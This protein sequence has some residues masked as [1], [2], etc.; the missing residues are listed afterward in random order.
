MDPSVE[1]RITKGE[2]TVFLLLV[3]ISVGFLQSCDDLTPDPQQDELRYIDYAVNLHQHGIFGLSRP[4]GVTQPGYANAPLYPAFLAGL[5][6]LSPRFAATLSCIHKDDSTREYCDTDYQVLIIAQSTLIVVALTC[7]WCL[8]RLLFA[9]RSIA[10][11]AVALA[12]ASTKPLFFTS[13]F[14]TEILI[15]LFFAMLLLSLALAMTRSHCGWWFGVGAVLGLLSLT[16]PEYLYLALATLTAVAFACLRGKSQAKHAAVLACALA[17]T[18]GP[19]LARNYA[20]FGR[21]AITGAYSDVILAYRLAYNN[22]SLAEWG[23]AFIYWLP[24]HGEALGKQLLPAHTYAKL[25]TDPKSYLY[26]EGSELFR[27]HLRAVDGDR[28]RLTAQLIKNEI[29]AHP[30]KHAFAALPLT[31]RGI[32]AGKYLAV[33]GVP[34]LIALLVIKIRRREWLVPA[35]TLPAAI[36]V[37][38]YAAVSVSIPRYNVYLIYYYGLATAWAMIAIA[39]RLKRRLRA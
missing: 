34:C 35:L 2:A 3:C 7:L 10:W 14:L 18:V 25:G 21:F 27:Q 9:N 29:I 30:F 28:K 1:R 16:R 15:L 22:M 37:A 13:H 39:D 24:G 5:M 31:W 12:L 32:L 33:T 4:G 6:A 26:V 8:A 38:L 20:H 11:L 23:A 36:M 19:W 17:L